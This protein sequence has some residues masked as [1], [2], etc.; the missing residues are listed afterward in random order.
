MQIINLTG[1]DITDLTTGT[2]YKPDGKVIRVSS[3]AVPVT[4]Y[5]G[6]RVCDYVYELEDGITLPAPIEG[7]LYLIS[8]MALN[9]VPSSR[10]DFIA[11]GPVQ[12]AKHSNTPLGCRG[13]RRK[14]HNT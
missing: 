4:G 5:N 12:K 8:N 3:K 6:I 13:F 14:K 10:T 9:A 2:T 11:P 7:T 1:H